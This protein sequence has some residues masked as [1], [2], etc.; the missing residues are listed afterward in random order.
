MIKLKR[1]G[2]SPRD[3]GESLRGDG[4]CKEHVT[5]QPHY[6]ERGT[7]ER[8]DVPEGVYPQENVLRVSGFPLWPALCSRILGYDHLSS[9]LLANRAF[10]Y[11]N[12]QALAVA[13]S[14]GA[15]FGWNDSYPTASELRRAI[16]AKELQLGSD[17]GDR[18]ALEKRT[19]KKIDRLYRTQNYGRLGFGTMTVAK[20]RVPYIDSYSLIV[21]NQE[22]YS[23]V[24]EISDLSWRKPCIF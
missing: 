14:T 11:E 7:C 17:Y 22:L 6:I 4:G 10:F 18:I 20:S 19:I 5:S 23:L 16:A 15:A 21:T 2:N 24:I 9:T 13:E 1:P 3:E 8:G 12:L